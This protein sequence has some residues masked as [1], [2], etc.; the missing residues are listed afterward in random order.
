MGDEEDEE[1]MNGDRNRRRSLSESQSMSMS[2]SMT[3]PSNIPRASFK[4]INY[5]WNDSMSK[6][7]FN[8]YKKMRQ[9]FAF[10]YKHSPR[11][12]R[13]DELAS[14]HTKLFQDALNDQVLK[15]NDEAMENDEENLNNDSKENL[16]Q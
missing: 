12:S 10:R 7:A 15:E 2:M 1:E 8:N 13:D 5:N 11:K 3:V 6:K 16:L 9:K 14:V 4:Q